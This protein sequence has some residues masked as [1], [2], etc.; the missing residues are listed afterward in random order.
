MTGRR[1]TGREFG[2]R[3]IWG[4]I[5]L[6]PLLSWV[7]LAIAVFMHQT[8]RI[9]TSDRLLDKFLQ[10]LIDR[11]AL[12]G[13]RVAS[14]VSYGYG[15]GELPASAFDKW[16]AE[17]G[18]DPRYWLLRCEY[19]ADDPDTDYSG[20]A[21][22]FDKRI[23]LLRTGLERG[24][25]SPAL[26][27]RL[28]GISFF[29]WQWEA[30]DICQ[31]TRPDYRKGTVDQWEAYILD[32]QRHLDSQHGSELDGQLKQLLEQANGEALPLY[33]AAD[34]AWARGDTAQA[35]KLLHAG[36]VAPRVDA[37]LI[38]PGEALQPGTPAAPGAVD[39]LIAAAMRGPRQSI[40]MPD[41]RR[42]VMALGQHAAQQGD[43]P[44][45][46]ELQ[47][48]LCRRGCIQQASAMQIASTAK[49]QQDLLDALNTHYRGGISS[50]QRKCL[51]DLQTRITALITS[52]DA[53]RKQAQ[54]SAVLPAAGFWKW[55]QYQALRLA[56]G[57]RSQ[58]LLELQQQAENRRRERITVE[59]QLLP[60]LEELQ[61]FDYA[62]LSWR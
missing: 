16:E 57:G 24:A 32:V 58:A 3:L 35:V 28:L 48:F 20:A 1:R 38:Y 31:L 46:A 37:L 33:L 49:R 21:H 55:W 8:P 34:I 6:M 43:L 56:T 29:D 53:A 19:Q 10:E 36:N 39:D 7:V 27:G 23:V 2:L 14:S 30:K 50:E 61:R 25:V 59:Q 60:Q 40:S 52:A 41:L 9:A 42:M 12:V 47:L 4:V 22:V 11:D 5:L 51:A 17:F 54:P 26:L 18:T 44:A 62:T 13:A 45:L 15:P